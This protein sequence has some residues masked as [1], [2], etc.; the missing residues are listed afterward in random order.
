M[1]A[2]W[3]GKDEVL[4][5]VDRANKGD[6]PAYPYSPSGE[7]VRAADWTATTIKEDAP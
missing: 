2:P 5:M 7:D 4:A 6:V 3:N 1:L